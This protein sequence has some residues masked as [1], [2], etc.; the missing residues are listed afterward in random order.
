MVA[1]ADGGGGPA[2]G[3][4][5]CATVRLWWVGLYVA[6]SRA[7][8]LPEPAGVQRLPAVLG[9]F[10]VVDLFCGGGELPL[11]VAVGEGAACGQGDG[12]DGGCSRCRRLW[13]RR[14]AGGGRCLR[15][16]GLGR[17]RRRL[18]RGRLR[19]GGSCWCRRR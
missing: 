9:R 3:S 12:G 14:P 8:G 1:L 15:R 16:R 18:G 17:C 5:A 13:R 6:G 11:E 19:G 4:L 10:G 7:V 2:G